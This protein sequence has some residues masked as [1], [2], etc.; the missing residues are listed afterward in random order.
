MA[1]G[2]RTWVITEGVPAPFQVLV[3]TRDPEAVESG[4]ELLF[5]VRLRE[6]AMGARSGTP[7]EQGLSRLE[8]MGSDSLREMWA[9]FKQ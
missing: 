7:Q 9:T 5:G 6:A 3:A 1:V 2:A 4:P 8:A